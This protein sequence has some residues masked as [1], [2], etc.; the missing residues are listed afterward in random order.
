M[1][2]RNLIEEIRNY[3]DDVPLVM[4][5]AARFEALLNDRRWIP[6]AERLPTNYTYV[7]AQWTMYRSNTIETSILSLNEYG[8]WCEERG[9][10]NGNVIAWMPLP[11]PYKPG[12]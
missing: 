5:L 2:D 3:F 11:E 10:P 6:V 7:L 4:E 12:E 8:E 1:S 9:C